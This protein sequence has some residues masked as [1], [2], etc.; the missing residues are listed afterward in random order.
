MLLVR[1]LHRA[2]EI[3]GGQF[4]IDQEREIAR[5][6]LQRGRRIGLAHRRAARLE[7]DRVEEQL[8]HHYRAVH[9]FEA[10]GA[11]GRGVQRAV[12]GEHVLRPQPQRRRLAG[13]IVIAWTCGIGGEVHQLG[14]RGSCGIEQRQHLGLHVMRGEALRLAAAPVA[15]GLVARQHD[16]ERGA[17]DTGA[18]LGLEIATAKFEQPDRARAAIEI[19]LGGREQPGQQRGAH[20][21]QV[22]ADRIGEHPV[23]AAKGRGFLVRDER[24]VD[25]LV[26]AA[27]SGETAHAAL[28]QL[29]RTGGR[30]G[31][32]GQARQRGRGD[33][34]DA[35]DAH[36]FLD[37]IR[38]ARDIAPP[39][40]D[41][42]RPGGGAAVDVEAQPLEDRLLLAC[43]HIDAAQ[44]RAIGG[45]VGD[46]ARLDRSCARPGDRARRAAAMLE[47]QPRRDRQALFEKRRI[48]ATFEA[49]ARIAR[50]HQLLAG[51]RDMFGVEIGTFDQHVGSVVGHPRILAAHDAT[52]I[53]HLG[54]VGDHSHAG[55]ER[56]ALAVKRQHLLAVRRLA[57]DQ[58]ARELRPVIDVQG[59]AQVDRDEIGDI[60]Q[61]RNRLLPDRLQPVRHPF[62]RGTVLEARDVL[63]VEGRAAGGIVG[64]DIGS[65]AAALDRIDA[66]A[67]DLGQGLQRTDAR[68]GEIARDA[69]HAHAIL[70]VGRDRHLDHRIVEARIIGKAGAHRCVLGQ[71]DDAVMI[72]AELELAVRAHHAKALDIA[73]LRG[74]QREGGA[75][76]IGSR[77]AEHADQP[78]PCIGRAA[79]DL[80]GGA[81]AVVDLEQPQ[82]VRIGMRACLEHP[83]D[84]ERAQRI[85]GV[86]H[87]F[88]LQ[89]DRGQPVGDFGQARIGIE[90]LF[91]PGEG[92]LH[93]PTPPLSVG[94]SSDENP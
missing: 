3:A 38:L 44:S 82:L 12:R 89:P 80:P 37:D 43:R 84:A 64:A 23:A 78:L 6:R 55:V 88:E 20:D 58:T 11:R 32:A 54:T 46:G 21:L 66:R 92:E 79:H 65:L 39:G 74:L 1:A 2:D 4:R 90:M 62:G 94:T 10:E 24:P 27:R 19:A 73:D 85:G 75:G 9:R 15:R 8:G 18:V 34:I 7:R 5:H 36:H 13:V 56:I 91:Q 45:V 40:R 52:D 72:L 47:H 22:L 17:F 87:P 69:A 35:G 53:V 28:L 83:G 76:D 77:R 59:A 61:H 26:E 31:D 68:C 71:F 81:R 14:G 57:R 33:R 30:P 48:D 42:D 16:A 25:R 41:G 93:A 49:L 50:Q 60:D 86:F 70:L 29:R 67:I 63:R 51:A